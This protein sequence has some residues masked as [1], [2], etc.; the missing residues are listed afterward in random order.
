MEIIS[1]IAIENTLEATGC[2][3]KKTWEIVTGRSKIIV[4]KFT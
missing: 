2:S 4:F 3:L 1:Q